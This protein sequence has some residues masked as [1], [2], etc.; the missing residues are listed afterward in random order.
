MNAAMIHTRPIEQ[1]KVRREFWLQLVVYIIGIHGLFVIATTML[2]QLGGRVGIHLSDLDLD[3][4]IDV[5]LL[6]GIGLVY[7]S[8]LL[9]RRKRTAWAVALFAYVFMLGFYANQVHLYAS[10]HDWLQIIAGLG[11]P[12]LNIS[13]LLQQ[14]RHFTVKSDIRSFGYALRVIVLVMLVMLVYGTAGFMLLSKHD[15]HH[16][17]SVGEAVHRTI[18]QFG[19][20]TSSDLVPATRRARVFVD[21]LSV[22]SI[23]A[24]SYAVIALFQPIRS[25]YAEHHAGGREAARRLLSAGG[26]SEDFFKLW[27][28]DKGYYFNPQETSGVA[29]RVRRGVA[30]VVGDPMGTQSAAGSM[31]DGFEDVCFGNDWQPAFI[32]TTPQWQKFYERRG[33]R[34]QKIGEEAVIDIADFQKNV[35]NTKYFR[36][37]SN[38]FAREDFTIEVLKP[39]HSPALIRRLHDISDSWL[40]RPG[41]SERSFMMGYF[42]EAYLQQCTVVVARD[43][44]GTIQAFLNQIPSCD[45]KEAN[46]DMLRHAEGSLG[47]INDFVLL[48]FIDYVAGG[49]ES[50]LNL[51]LCPLSGMDD[52]EEKSL[53]SRTLHFVYSNGDRFYSFSGLRR[54]KAKYKPQW[55]VRSVAYKGGPANFIRA[56][57]ALTAAMRVKR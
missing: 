53:M 19:L 3:I 26:N 13:L 2:Y 23:A 4:D 25:R 20:T 8:T 40:K 17:I 24:V 32:H 12:V 41:R 57:N 43:S 5:P 36:Q 50:H 15:F 22:I 18:D 54:F 30:L 48:A 10:H 29:Y 1:L 33:Y 51:G 31:L 6:I 37:V 11:L 45:P 21:S 49:H 47:N 9:R 44:A 38:K 34:L 46:F 35:R 27:P 16:E 28:E 52:L 42:S 39:P 14:R 55:R 7:L 56:M